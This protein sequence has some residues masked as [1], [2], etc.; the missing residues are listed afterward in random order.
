MAPGLDQEIAQIWNIVDKCM[1]LSNL[2]RNEIGCALQ[3]DHEA[4]KQR[5]VPF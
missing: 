3:A 5:K 1:K 2:R 4:T